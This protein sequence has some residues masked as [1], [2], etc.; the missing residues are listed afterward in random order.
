MQSKAEGVIAR[1]GTYR[2]EVVTAEML[3]RYIQYHD[4]IPL[5]VGPHPK[6]GFA[7]PDEY[8]GK[9]IPK[10]NEQR[11]VLEGSFWFFD[12]GWH[13][14]PDEVK[15][16]LAA[17][18]EIPLSVGYETETDDH[19]VQRW[20]KWDHIALGVKNPAIEGV[21]VN[22]RAE[23]DYPERFRTEE[24]EIMAEKEEPAEARPEQTVTM[25]K[26]ELQTL[27]DEAVTKA[28]AARPEVTE[29]AEPETT[30]E[31]ETAPEAEEETRPDP[32]PEVVLPASA[33]SK[34]KD[35]GIEK[36]GDWWKF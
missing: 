6:G 14:V 5:I 30:T 25:T 35:D 16:K 15:R 10:W 17:K 1:P 32:V 23:E 12:E 33:P 36:V 4:S 22:F 28:V 8:I 7:T 27:I 29:E 13:R 19:N 2:D 3:K 18:Q 31:T 24:A 26:A 21:G 11:Q 9:V 20:R 34:K